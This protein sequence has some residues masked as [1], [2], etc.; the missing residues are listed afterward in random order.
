M[1]TQK[2]ITVAGVTLLVVILLAQLWLSVRRQSQTFDEAC[3][4][5]AGYRYWTSSDFGF[6]PEHPPL[7]KLLS[8]L[9]LLSLH[10][11]VP[12]FTE[13]NFK[14][15]EYAAA[16]SFLYSNN[17]DRVLNRARMAASLLTLCL[18]IA[19][20]LC[21]R[22]MYGR[23]PSWLAL[24]LFVFEPNILAHGALVATDMAVTC[25]LFVAVY[26]FYR[27]IK[28]P[29]TMR[30]CIA[31]V[32]VGLTLGAKHSGILVFPILG[33]LALGQWALR[34]STLTTGEEGPKGLLALAASLVAITAVAVTVLW[35]LYGFR[36][37]ARQPGLSIVP[38]L[39]EYVQ[40][41]DRPAQAA[42]ILKIQKWQLLPEAYLYGLADVLITSEQHYSYV[43]GKLYPGGRWFYFPVAVLVKS[44]IPLL[45][46]LGLVPFIFAKR[47]REYGREFLFL[48]IPVG[49]YLAV[50]MTSGF[51]LGVRHILPI[52]P[53]LIVLAAAAAW[54]AAQ[55]RRYLA[56]AVAVVLVLHIVSSLR[57][58]PNYLAYSNEIAG[59]P[60]NT[61]KVLADSNVDWG[62]SLKFTKEYLDRHQIK[63][64]W[65]AYF[66]YAVVDPASYGISC[67]PLPTGIATGIQVPTDIVPS[68]IQGPVLVS[69]NE[70]AGIIWGPG[71]LNPYEQFQRL[72][73]VDSIGDSIL[74]FRGQFD[75][76]V[77]SAQTHSIVAWQLAQTN[78]MEEAVAEA[79]R[80]V[81]LAP[82]SVEIRFEL[83]SI[84]KMMKKNDEARQSFQEALV[85]AETVYPQYQKSWLS[86]VQQAMAE[87]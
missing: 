57:T 25:F 65:F 69:V 54:N 80:A 47:F 60:K 43:L 1:V 71:D 58:F 20:F 18:C 85:L 48:T 52:F 45:L 82:N 42:V 62:Q 10:L 22:E 14:L 16:Q 32:A 86:T 76:P 19:V 31:G 84:L 21:A 34:R 78:H 56:Y 6:N 70:I 30:L 61:Y 23:G 81:T 75:I 67:K 77:I 64:C 2:A 24:V 37:Q 44:T 68:T 28:K 63:D 7:A 46:F 51:N 9:P 39:S 49:L 15:M 17:A 8:A 53:F 38:A 4:T 12:P 3:H 33:L 29:T 35:S 74:V 72:Q 55:R 36:Y 5:F 83:G 40:Q 41:M 13:D 11:K 79:K 73:P 59:G 26:T 27:Y 66:G 87:Q 50:S